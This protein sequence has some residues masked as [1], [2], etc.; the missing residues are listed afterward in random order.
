M[1]KFYNMFLILR[2]VHV[3]SDDRDDYYMNNYAD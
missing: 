2:N 1:I 3:I